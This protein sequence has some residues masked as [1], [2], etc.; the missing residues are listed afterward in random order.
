MLE[1]QKLIDVNRI[2]ITKPVDLTT[3]LNTGLYKIAPDQH[4]FGIQ[5]T[6][7]G[8]DIFSAKINLEVQW[9]SDLVIAAIERNG[10]VITTAY[11]DIHSLHV[12]KDTKAF[13]ERG[14]VY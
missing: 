3:I 9:A 11:Y 4:Q 6:D 1:M 14:M 2:D 8:A 13:F 7:E 10:G 12:M 5:L